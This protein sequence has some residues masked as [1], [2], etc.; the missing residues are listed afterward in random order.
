MLAPALTSSLADWLK[1]CHATS[2]SAVFPSCPFKQKEN[3][4][5]IPCN[6][7][8]VFFLKISVQINVSKLAYYTSV[9]KKKIMLFI[10]QCA[11]VYSSPIMVVDQCG[12]VSYSL[13][14]RSIQQCFFSSSVCRTYSTGMCVCVYMC[15]FHLVLPVQCTPFLNERC[16]DITVS[17][18]SCSV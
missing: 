18:H 5:R 2:C 15:V 14:I 1:P 12:H 9:V 7:V 8:V 11:C 16:D 10:V 17:H 3:A 13:F 4:V 6:D